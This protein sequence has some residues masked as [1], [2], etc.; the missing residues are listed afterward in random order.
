VELDEVRRAALALPEATEE[1]HFDLTSFRVRGKIFAT[2]PPVGDEVRIF[3]DDHDARAAVTDDPAVFEELWWGK[4]LSG[5]RVRLPGAPAV[6]VR[7]LLVEA[8][9]RKAP[10]RV[11]AAYEAAE[12]PAST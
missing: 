12:G 1:P 10:K 6:L 3:V 4:R 9:R 2:A 8:W 5:L 11:V 7:E